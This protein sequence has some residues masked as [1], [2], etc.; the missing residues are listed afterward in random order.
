MK[1]LGSTKNKITE[2]ENGEKVL[3]LEIIEVI[4]VHCNIVNKDY[5]QGSR[6]FYTFAPNKSFVQL[7][8]ILPKNFIFLKSFDSELPTL[9]HDL[10]I[11]ILKR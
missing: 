9:K 3:H 4:L 7:L 5:Q 2:D 10:L 6:V 1:L 8:D 11:K